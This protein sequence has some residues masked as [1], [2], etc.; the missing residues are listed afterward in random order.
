MDYNQG[1]VYGP[2]YWLQCIGN[3]GGNIRILKSFP[4]VDSTH[5]HT[6]AE[7]ILYVSLSGT[8]WT[9]RRL[10]VSFL[11]CSITGNETQHHHYEQWSG[12]V[13]FSSKKNSSAGNVI[14][15]VIWDRKGVILLKFKQP[16]QTINWSLHWVAD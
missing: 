11:D 9:K 10:K 12:D 16:R 8:N 13:N 1:I 3:D 5:S 15:P 2:E 14:C 7:R 6:G 4:Q